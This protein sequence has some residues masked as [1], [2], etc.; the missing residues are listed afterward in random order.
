[1]GKRKQFSTEEKSKVMCWGEIRIK[2]KEIAARLGRRERADWIH[3]SVL[4]KLPP[5]GSP[6]PPKARSGRPS[7]ASQDQRLKAYVEKY[8]FKLARQLKNQVVCWADFLVRTL[9]KQLQNHFFDFRACLKNIYS[10][11]PHMK[12][13]MFVVGSF[14]HNNKKENCYKIVCRRRN[15]HRQKKG[16]K[17]ANF[18]HIHIIH[19]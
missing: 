11:E 6:P 8:P 16:I 14:C 5:N 15:R 18:F 12:L 2:S 10:L 13:A 1:M 17:T 4:K 9:Q 19:T 7:K 3:L